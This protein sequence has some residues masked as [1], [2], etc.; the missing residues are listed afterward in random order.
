M[1]TIEQA[2]A[3]HITPVKVKDLPAFLNA[4]EPVARDLAGG[5]IITA[6]SHHA[7]DVIAATAI[8]AGV[9]RAELEEAT[10]DVL[11]L[12]AT[13]VMEVNAD[14]FVR[15]VLPLM[16]AAAKKIG[17]ISTPSS[18]SGS[19]GSAAQGSDTRKR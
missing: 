6:L 9:P 12:L 7:E 18:T 1:L 15:Q 17:S 3:I 13:R 19:S 16:T 2:Q 10:P 4:V 8:G 11:V 5:D 14:F